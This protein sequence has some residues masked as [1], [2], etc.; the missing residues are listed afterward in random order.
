MTHQYLLTPWCR[1]LLEELN[2]LQLVKKSLPIKTLCGLIPHCSSF[3]NFC[4]HQMVMTPQYIDEVPNNRGRFCPHTRPYVISHVTPP[5]TGETIQ[6]EG[7][8]Y[9]GVLGAYIPRL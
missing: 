4:N 5:R 2:G 8:R 6:C 1:V 9:V 7:V 3:P